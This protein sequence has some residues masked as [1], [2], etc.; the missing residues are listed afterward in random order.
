MSA[1]ISRTSPFKLRPYQADVV[2]LVHQQLKT[3]QRVLVVAGTGAGKTVIASHITQDFLLQ[4]KKVL[5]LVHRDILVKQ[6][7]K[8]FAHLP[9]GIIA[10]RHQ[11]NLSQ[12]LQVASVQTLGRKGVEWLNYHFP[13]HVAIFDES[14]LTNW[15]NFS[16]ELF[17]R[18][19]LSP[20]ERTVCIGL[21]ATPWRRSK[22]QAMGD[23]YQSSVYAPL[24]GELIVKGFLVPFAYFSIGK[25]EKK[26]LRIRNGEYETVKLKVRCNTPE[27]IQHIVNEWK[28][29]AKGRPTIVFT[30]DIEHA[31]AIAQ[32]FNH[33]GISAA[34]VDGTMKIGDREQIYEQLAQ[35]KIQVVCSCEALS[36]G[37]DVPIVSCVVLARLTA[38]KAKYIQQIGRGARI[39][40]DGEKRDCL[41]LDAV[42]LVEE[43]GFF[44]DISYEDLALRTSD[45]KPDHKTPPPMK[46][47]PKCQQ[48]MLG[49][50][51]VCSNEKCRHKFPPKYEVHAPKKLKLVIPE[52]SRQKY[53]HYQKLIKQ[54][55]H[56]QSSFVDADNMFRS[57]YGHYPPASWRKGAIFG[58]SPSEKEKKNYLNYLNLLVRKHQIK[59]PQWIEKN[60]W[61]F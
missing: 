44:E 50:L 42:G 26:G 61:E 57:I 1:T 19:P 33:Q 18:L 13:F 17:P 3:D 9:H 43:F 41:I 16:L 45:E 39:T 23:L 55:Y 37:F 49:S 4:N 32:A 48:L 11:L 7:V 5:F 38:S 20:Y 36:E 14:H 31:Q 56:Q 34:S 35:E 51:Q 15:F 40:P 60:C 22:Y 25:V 24:P 53:Q 27:V 52:S 2:K 59:D 29:K 6:T 12:P 30:I 8:K 28:D 21:T 10:G 54:A 46:T 47:C 58:E